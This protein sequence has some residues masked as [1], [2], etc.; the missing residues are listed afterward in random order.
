M[1]DMGMLDS[2]YK[3]FP[4]YSQWCTAKHEPVQWDSRNSDLQEFKT[5]T[6]KWQ[7]AIQGVLN[8]AALDTGAIEDLYTTDRGFT[9]SV[10][11]ATNAVAL[12]NNERGEDIAAIYLAQQKVYETFLHN[13]VEYDHISEVTIRTLHAELLSE[14]KTYRAL[15]PDGTFTQKEL[16]RGSYKTNP[17][18]VQLGNGSYHSYCPVHEV[19]SEMQ[20]LIDVM[21]SETFKKSA[22][23][24]QISYVHY[25]ITVIHPFQDG[26]GRVARALASVFCMKC[27]TI[28]FLVFNDQ[29]PEYLTSL[30]Q[31]DTGSFAGFIDFVTGCIVDTFEFVTQIPAEQES[32]SADEILTDIASLSTT[33]AGYDH[34]LVTQKSFDLMNLFMSSLVKSGKNK[35]I[36]GTLEFRTVTLS[37]TSEVTAPKGYSFKN[38]DTVSA[39]IECHLLKPIEVSTFFVVYLLE[40]L[41]YQKWD[42]YKIY[43]G[44]ASSPSMHQVSFN[45]IFAARID[46]F[47]KNQKFSFS[48]RLKLATDRI[49]IDILEDI[50]SNAQR[51]LSQS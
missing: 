19:S 6:A 14:Q 42:A 18:H 3:Q 20:L 39:C 48:T 30:Q 8:A 9:V 10:A 2:Q 41:N 32:R 7:R 40:P 24:L 31:A 33:E 5:D 16:P 22:C 36:R 37:H 34:Q 43:A 38:I 15:M 47:D 45:Q 13:L 12:V 28:P 27:F 49:I 4:D 25:A 44:A 11:S 46:E 50:N 26:N 23:H 35:A 51:K 29:K 1:A 17:N 21:N